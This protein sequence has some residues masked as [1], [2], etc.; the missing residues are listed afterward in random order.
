[1]PLIA[2]VPQDVPFLVGL[3]SG[4]TVYDT[5][6]QARDA[7][8]A[9]TTGNAGT[10]YLTAKVIESVLAVDGGN[11][12]LVPGAPAAWIIQLS[13]TANY[14]Q[15]SAAEVAAEALSAANSNASVLIGRAFQSVTGP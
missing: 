13:T 6:T 7:A 9:L 15:R 12:N 10:E 3:A 1:M 11:V 8:V 2:Q 5:Y 14:L 4:F